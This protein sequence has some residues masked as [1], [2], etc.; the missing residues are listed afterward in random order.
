MTA[1]SLERQVASFEERYGGVPA[2]RRQPYRVLFPLGAVLAVAGVGHWLL[3]GLGWLAEYRPVFHA[4]TQ[5]QGFLMSFA[6]GFLMTAVPRRTGTAP[7]SGFEVAVAAAAPLGATILAWWQAW[8]A[9]QLCWLA[10]VAMLLSFAVR[11]FVAK[12]ASRR[13]PASF[14]W[15]PWSLAMGLAGSGA[16]AAQGAFG[17]S[18]DVHELGRRLLLQGM[19][20]GLVL[21]VGGLVLPLFT[22]GQGPPDA[23]PADR[24]ARFGH[25]LGAL[26]L[27]GTFV[28]EQY[29]PVVA[30]RAL[31]AALV[32][33]VLC[34]GA[35]LYRRPTVPGLHRRFVWISA[36]LVPVG[37]AIAACV[38]DLPQMGQHVVF[39]GGFA[40][41]AFSVG[42]HVA[43]AH[44]GRQDLVRRSPWPV[45]WFGA[46]F[47]AA[48]VLRALVELDPMRRPWWLA[49]AAGS[50]LAGVALWAWVVTPVLVKARRRG[51][52]QRA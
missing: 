8:A 27:A 40:W 11:R 9:T 43:L 25:T 16:I 2:W 7:P 3:F 34:L 18:F 24:G 35:R 37:Y 29:G 4:I 50:F 32:L 1:P 12:D 49:A 33:V 6:L 51:G 45:P 14:V 47:S 39:V 22:R 10:V 31:R 21:G 38:P 36:W 48:T 26:A 17:F 13:P 44:G 41:M 20:V 23:G 19:F 28:L 42:L 52:P 15:I 30:A 5:I 46:A